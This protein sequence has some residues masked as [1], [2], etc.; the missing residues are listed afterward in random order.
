MSIRARASSFTLACGLVLIE[1]LFA[2]TAAVAAEPAQATGSTGIL[3]TT[4]AIPAPREA[5]IAR[6]VV[7]TV[8][9]GDIAIVRGGDGRIFVPVSDAAKWG[10]ALGDAAT[11][12]F[13]GERYV[14]LAAM[15]DVKATFNAATVTVEVT[16]AA[17]AFSQNTLD[18]RPQ[19]RANVTFPSD[20]S[21]F[22]NYGVNAA[23]DENAQNR[24]YQ[25][26]TELAART[27]NWLF[28]NTTT[29]AWGNI[30]PA[31]FIR[32][33]T[34]VQYDDRANLRRFTAGDFFTPTFDLANPVP[35]AGLSLTKFYAMDPYFIQYPTA[36]FA[37]EVALPSTVLVRVDGNLIAQRQVQAGPLAISNITGIVGAQNVSVVIRDPFG[38]EQVLQQPFFYAI[39]SGL[40]KGLHEYSY[41]LGFL[42]ENYG[43]TSDDYGPLAASAF[44]RYAFTDDVTLGVRGQASSNLFNIGPFGTLQTPRFGIVGGGVSVGG[45]GHDMSPAGSIAYA[46][47]GHEFSLQLGSRYF[48]RHYAQLSDAGVSFRSRSSYYI[49]GS[50]YLQGAGTVSA[51]YN[52]SST[53]EGPSSTVGNLGY[54]LGVLGG[55]GLVALNYTRTFEPASAYTWLASFR[56]QFDEFTSVVGGVGG[57]QGGNSQAVSLQRSLPQ[58]EGVG[59]DLTIGHVQATDTDPVYG[60]AFVQAN[61]QFA[62]VGVEYVRATSTEGPPGLSRVFA[63]GSIAYV[64]GSVVA[65]RPVDDSFALVRLGVPDVPVYAN[66]WF[67]GRTNARGEAFAN[68][69]ASYYDNSISFDA[70]DL[71][72]D[73]VYPI[74]EQ[75]IA[76]PLRSGTLVAFAIRKNR[77]IQGS[78]I[79]ITDGKRVALEFREIRLVKGDSTI[80]SFTARQGEFYVEGVEP[81]DYELQAAGA[82]PCTATVRVPE[83][84]DA[85]TSVGQ[86]VCTTR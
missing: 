23:G 62:N 4:P 36:G 81:G 18:F 52:A 37:T 48:G 69:L 74:S 64:G 25:F 17:K 77:A 63:A 8:P 11:F 51:T 58:G 54:T 6:I 35:M 27:G 44:H 31:G 82:A 5:I 85:M 40:A 46:Y 16:I 45:D 75:T 72:L 55:K 15:R 79:G 2:S 41:N 12:V 47:T 71:G 76:P 65:S 14:D 3:G 50:Y 24:S 56:Y 32:L 66:G 21:V 84:V 13:E 78:L 60:R 9:R 59:Y 83:D 29:Q 20:T 10:A 22:L 28:Y 68:N 49:S 57:G 67:V 53:Y 7:N 43:I 30:T 42:R 61:T 73:Y 26:S 80:S 39:N 34:N 70:R 19:R 33:L 38:R 86:I 1:A